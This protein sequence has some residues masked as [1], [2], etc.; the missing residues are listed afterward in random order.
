MKK[1]LS[2]SY[3][4][5]V[6]SLI[7]AAGIVF[8]SCSK[9]QNNVLSPVQ[10][11]S[12]SG[13]Y[14]HPA[15]WSDSS[16]ASFHGAYFINT[17]VNAHKFDLTSCASCHGNDLAGGSTKVSCYKCH[18]GNDGT[19]AC[20]TCHGSLLNPAPPKDLSGNS[21]AANPTVGAHQD[22]LL[23]NSFTSGVACSSCHAVPRAAGPAMHPTGGNISVIFSGVATTET[24][25][26]ESQYYDATQ[27]TIIP[28][29]AF[30][31]ETLRCSNTYCHGNFKNGNNFTP[32]W[33]NGDSTQAACGTCHSVPPN[34]TIHQVAFYHGPSEQNCYFCH[35]PM[36]GQNGIQDSTLHVNG[37]LE[38]YG[39]SLTAW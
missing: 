33:K 9:L 3:Q 14:P 28:T 6:V 34:T 5:S 2:I 35:E 8:N 25:T 13:I 18:Q 30:N 39:K 17:Y 1:Y 27:P 29:P 19:L 36:M 26:A 10:S 32:T 12:Q 11:Q 24:N 31:V 38:L 15:G 7:I 20:N 23:G 37:K 21:L 22:H 16:S 4:L